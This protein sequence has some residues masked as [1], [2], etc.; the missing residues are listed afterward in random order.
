MHV[1][2]HVPV[3]VRK[4]ACSKASMEARDKKLVKVIA[5]HATV[6]EREDELGKTSDIY[7]DVNMRQ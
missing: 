5:M 4:C 6:A 2:M 7:D 1:V 3:H